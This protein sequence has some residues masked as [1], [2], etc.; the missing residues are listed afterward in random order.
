MPIEV[1]AFLGINGGTPSCPAIRGEV[2]AIGSCAK[3]AVG[4]GGTVLDFIASA[5]EVFHFCPHR[6][7]IGSSINAA[8][9]AN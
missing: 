6:T 8:V 2:K 3:Y 9:N 1:V 4:V 5:T 7:A